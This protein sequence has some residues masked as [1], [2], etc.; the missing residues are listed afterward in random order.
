METNTFL[1]L[2]TQERT[3]IERTLSSVGHKEKIGNTTMWEPSF[4][5]LNTLRSEQSEI[6]DEYEEFDNRI[7]VETKLVSRLKEIDS[8]LAR[9]T[10]HTY[11]TCT[12]GGEP[13]AEDRLMANPAA[14]TCITHAPKNTE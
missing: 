1:D 3:E 6:A 9:I 4:P 10:A 2:L 5:E 14:I 7:G 11:G 13:I 12:V 8:A